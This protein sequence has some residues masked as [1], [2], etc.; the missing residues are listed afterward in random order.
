MRKPTIVMAAALVLFAVAAQTSAQG[1]V[2]LLRI[3][4][5]A[6]A[7]G[8]VV[9]AEAVDAAGPETLDAPPVS[10]VLIVHSAASP[11][12]ADVEGL[13]SGSIVPAVPKC[14]AGWERHVDAKGEP[15]FFQFGLVDKS[16]GTHP[17]AINY[18][19]LACVKP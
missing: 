9:E 19:L 17:D 6:L 10:P 3:A 1:A 11:E 18:R 4:A 16:G 12:D 5:G 8:G 14:P 2:S 13:P 15:L 7:A